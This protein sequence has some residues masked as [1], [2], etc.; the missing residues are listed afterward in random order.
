M[1]TILAS[2]ALALL[3][4]LVQAECPYE[5]RAALSCPE[6]TQWDTNAKSCITPSS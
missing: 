1:K 5:K 2:V 6:G 3:P 4:A